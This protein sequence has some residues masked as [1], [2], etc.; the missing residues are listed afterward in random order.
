MSLALLM[1]PAQHTFCGKNVGSALCSPTRQRDVARRLLQRWEPKSITRN[2]IMLVA[3]THKWCTGGLCSSGLLD[4]A[5]PNVHIRVVG[6]SVCQLSNVT[7]TGKLRDAVDFII[8]T[9]RSIGLPAVELVFNMNDLPKVPV[10]STWN[11]PSSCAP[12]AALTEHSPLER[13]FDLQPYVNHSE[14]PILF[15]WATSDSFYDVPFPGY[16]RKTNRSL[17]SIQGTLKYERRKQACLFRGRCFSAVYDGLL[18]PNLS[19]TRIADSGV[20]PA[21][22]QLPAGAAPRVAFSVASRNISFLDVAVLPH[23][24]WQTTTCVEVQGFL[25]AHGL[26]RPYVREREWPMHQCLV[27]LDG[28]GASNRLAELLHSGSAIIKQRSE[29]REWYYELLSEGIHYDGARADASD[30]VQVATRLL[31][32]HSHGQRLASCAQAFAQSCLTYAA[33]MSFFRQLMLEYATKLAFDPAA[34]SQCS[35]M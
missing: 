2:K 10:S 22:R 35:G 19:T 28:N 29:W 26:V 20:V 6:R 34:D 3:D 12:F 16:A 32:N 15:S 1:L 31:E 27:H 9:A 33:Q 24:R 7:L 23:L 14:A 4:R 21:P 18:T 25:A 30:F 13:Y 11:C 17:S 8:D 5:P